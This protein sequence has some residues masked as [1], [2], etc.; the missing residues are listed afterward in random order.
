MRAWKLKI[1]IKLSK[2]LKKLTVKFKVRIYFCLL[3]MFNVATVTLVG[4]IVVIP[5]RH[6]IG[7][8]LPKYCKGKM[9]FF[10]YRSC[11]KDPLWIQAKDD[12]APKVESNKNAIKFCFYFDTLHHNILPLFNGYSYLFHQNTSNVNCVFQD[13][14]GKW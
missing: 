6:W 10:L 9:I 14:T 8:R 13:A 7:K 1:Q 4:G 11:S 3:I 5:K 2:H 12:L